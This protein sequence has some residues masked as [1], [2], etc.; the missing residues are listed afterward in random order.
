MQSAVIWT[1]LDIRHVTES[2]HDATVTR[3]PARLKT[4]TMIVVSISSDPFAIGTSAVFGFGVV[5][6]VVGS[7]DDDIIIIIVF[8]RAHRF[9]DDDFDDEKTPL[10]TRT[11]KRFP[12]PPLPPPRNRIEDDDD[13]NDDH[14]DNIF[15]TTAHDQT[16]TQESL[17]SLLRVSKFVQK[18]KRFGSLVLSMSLDLRLGE[19]CLGYQKREKIN[20]KQGRGFSFLLLFKSVFS[21]ALG[22]INPTR[23]Y[24][25]LL[26]ARTQ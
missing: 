3:H 5:V 8:V 10:P 23:S 25:T 14:D 6:V 16:T 19:F 22:C 15:T 24:P 26:Y 11:T 13:V 17:D 9:P 7:D 4:S 18:V 1:S 21:L 2:S 20:P 12:P